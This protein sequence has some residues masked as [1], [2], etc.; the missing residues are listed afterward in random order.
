VQSPH[1]KGAASAAHIPDIPDIPE[2]IPGI[3]GSKVS[4]TAVPLSEY[5]FEF[6]FPIKTRGPPGAPPITP[7]TP[8]APTTPIQRPIKKA[9]HPFG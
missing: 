3:P 7:T 4:K 6:K 8:I 9:G 2:I 1:K 5:G